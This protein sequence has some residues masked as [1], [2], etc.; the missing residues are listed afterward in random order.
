[1]ILTDLRCPAEAIPRLATGI[2]ELDRVLG[3]GLVPGSTVLLSGDP[4]AGK[5][6]LALQVA[7]A[8]ADPPWL[9][10]TAYVT[11]EESAAQ[12]Q[13]R[14]RRL[15]ISGS[16]VRLAA[17][18]DLEAALAA[19]GPATRFLVIDSIQ[20]MRLAGLRGTVGGG[21]QATACLERIIA[22]ARTWR[23]AALVICH[24]TKENRAAGPNKLAHLVD[25]VLHLIASGPFRALEVN[26]NRFGRT[27]VAGLFKMTERGL[28]EPSADRSAL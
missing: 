26:K 19:A 20:T 4:G 3:G 8:I 9:V 11:A 15:G 22:C 24:V 7:A 23:C 18:D 6:T 27:D 25:V 12:L 1:M 17:T 5:S 21:L 14:A 28:R 10:R 16:P 2:A 13:G